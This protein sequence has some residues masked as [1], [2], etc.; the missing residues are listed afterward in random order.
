MGPLDPLP[1]ALFGGVT[2]PSEGRRGQGVRERSSDK[3]EALVWDLRTLD[4]GLTANQ[5]AGD[6]W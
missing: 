1:F 2:W 5:A 4:W 3:G 6:G